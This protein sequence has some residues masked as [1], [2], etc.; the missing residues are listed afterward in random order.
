MQRGVGHAVN[1]GAD[2]TGDY[3]WAGLPQGVRA[4][5]CLPALV[6]AGSFVG[7]GAFVASL[8]IDLAAGLASIVLIWALPGQVV[9][10]DMWAKGADVL[11][12]ALAVSV[13]AVRLLP[14][15]VLVLASARVPGAPRWPE[16]VMAHFTAVTIWIMANRKIFDIPPPRRLPWLL[17][18]GL[19]LMAGMFAFMSLGF[20]L[21]DWLPPVL[22]AALVFFTPAFFLLSL[23]ASARWRFD[24]LAIGLGALTWP[25]ATALVPDFDLLVAGLIGGTAAYVLAPPRRKGLL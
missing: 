7:F 20:V 2:E 5:V 4:A 22:A 25:I 21:A 8:G 10:M 11:V 12:I 24:Y 19:G 18:L 3:D 1:A 13:T 17:G 23:V 15:V 14:M 9:F 16:F 6:M